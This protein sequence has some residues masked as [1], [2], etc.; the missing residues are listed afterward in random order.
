[1]REVEIRFISFS[2]FWVYF[3]KILTEA[4]RF[5]VLWISERGKGS[6]HRSNSIPLNICMRMICGSHTNLI[7]EL[8]LF[9]FPIPVLF[10]QGW[11]RFWF[12]FWFQSLTNSMIPILIPIQSKK[13][14]LC[15]WFRFQHHAI[16]ILMSIPTKQALIPILILESD[17]DFGIIYDSGLY[18]TQGTSSFIL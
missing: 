2:V 4:W 11:F 8:Q 18:L 7:P 3:L 14:W 6:W 10:N 17:S 13:I 9:M 1:M 12:W 5:I 15:F 16:P